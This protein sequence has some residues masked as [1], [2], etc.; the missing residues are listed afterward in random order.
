MSAQNLILASASPRRVQL[1][2]QIG[3]TPS[4]I[5]P[6]DI[7]ETPFKGELP[8]DL[9]QRL[10]IGKAE[11]IAKTNPESFIL[12][13]DTVVGVGRRILPKT[14]TE[15]EARACL[16]LISGR[17]H[18]VYGGIALVTP[19]GKVVKRCI[20]TRVKFKPLSDEE[21]QTY[22]DSGQWSGVAGGYA[23]QG[24]ASAYIVNMIGSYSNVVGLSLYD[25][26]NMLRGAGAIA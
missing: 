14:E 8:R 10:A 26:M 1:L 13:A 2:E 20:E 3:I 5:I 25:T 21:K 7:D 12:G 11:E 9:A 16:D 19:Q 23:I 18:R 15:D 17:S 22:L 6:A 4:Q 24:L